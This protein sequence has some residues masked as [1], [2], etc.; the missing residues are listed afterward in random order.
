M[1][2][3]DILPGPDA[4]I[5]YDEFVAELF[6][7]R[8][9]LSSPVE[10]RSASRYY[11]IGDIH[12]DLITFRRILERIGE[13]GDDEVLITLGDYGDRGPYQ[14]ETWIGI[15][16]LKQVLRDRYVPLRGNH[17]PDAESVPYPHDITDKL[18][19]R[20]G[21]EKSEMAYAEL[22]NTFQVLPLVFLGDDF[23]AL[24]GGFPIHPFSL[25]NENEVRRSAHEILWNDPFEGL[26]FMPSPRGI[27]FLF[28]KDITVKWLTLNSKR[29]LI[30]GHEP[31]EGYKL[32]H[33]GLVITVFSRI[34]EPYFNRT[35][36]MAVIEG[37]N[38]SFELFY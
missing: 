11:V 26:G 5:S 13:I 30:R 33:D 17:E 2:I 19:E 3:S 14:V 27:G 34:G 7:L 9:S 21:S 37:G 32:N 36:A 38:V 31:A 15:S 25:D 1:K 20:F 29:F 6:K 23:I 24:H 16:A 28:G 35:A 18:R 10:R 8:S 22:F 4:R 12:G